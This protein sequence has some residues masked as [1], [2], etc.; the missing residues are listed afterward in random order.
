[1]KGQ[2]QSRGGYH[3]THAPWHRKRVP[4]TGRACYCA[5]L[6]T[7]GT[8]N[9]NYRDLLRRVVCLGLSGI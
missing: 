3:L 6:Y 1:M 4:V 7:A 8:K 2:R 5:G 9:S